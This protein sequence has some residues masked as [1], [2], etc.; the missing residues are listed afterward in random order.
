M[1]DVLSRILGG[2]VEVLV[3]ADQL[4]GQLL[5][6]CLPLLACLG[7]PEHRQSFLDRAVSLD[8]LLNL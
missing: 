5:P 7:L 3:Q 1:P 2:Q 6:G 4:L 8:I